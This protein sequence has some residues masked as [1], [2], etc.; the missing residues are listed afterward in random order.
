MVRD[1]KGQSLIEFALIVPI[2]ILLV[3]GIFDFGRVLY[4]YMNLNQ[5]AQETVRLGG[6]GKTDTEIT[7]FAQNRFH[8]GNPGSLVIKISPNQAA[9]KS[10]DYVTVTLKYPVEYVTP[11]ASLFLPSPY[12]VTTD[13]TIRVE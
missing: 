12:Q 2:L 11:M 7:Q 4:T 9:R 8:I 10:G 5:L 1:E 3:S 6:L 13:S